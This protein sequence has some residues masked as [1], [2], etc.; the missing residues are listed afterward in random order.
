M[1]EK[2]QANTENIASTTFLSLVTTQ[3]YLYAIFLPLLYEVTQFTSVL[4]S[5]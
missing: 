4:P 3:D 2:T 5:F 1:L